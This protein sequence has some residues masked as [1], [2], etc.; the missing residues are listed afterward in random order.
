MQGRS[1]A[2][3]VLAATAIGACGLAVAVG[4]AAAGGA[5]KSKKKLKPL[6]EVSVEFTADGETE[7]TGECKP[8]QEAVAGGFYIERPGPVSIYAPFESARASERG[9]S[10][11]VYGEPD[12]RSVTAYAYCDKKEPGLKTKEATESLKTIYGNFVTARCKLGQEAVSG[13]F[14]LPLSEAIVIASKRT[15]TRGWTLE[16]VGA[17]GTEVTVFAYCDK[18]EPG[19]K[20]KTASVVP[21]DTQDEATPVVARCK[22]KQ[23]LRSGG[24]EGEYPGGMTSGQVEGSRR[25]GKRRWEVTGIGLGPDRGLTAYAYCDK[26][27]RK[28]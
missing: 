2:S 8:G 6:K 26:K 7:R 14:E 18:R 16:V 19:L 24:F 28:K 20:T 4:G 25:V 9:W 1:R 12:P 22:R 21:P 13:G 5:G 11:R 10:S 17:P 15:G 27:E 3:R 23:Q